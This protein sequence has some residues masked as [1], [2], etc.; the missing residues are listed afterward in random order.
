LL[1]DSTKEY[2]FKFPSNGLANMRFG[3]SRLWRS[4][5][6]INSFVNA[7]PKSQPFYL[8]S[9]KLKTIVVITLNTNTTIIKIII[10]NKKFVCFVSS[11]NIS[12]LLYFFRIW[13]RPYY[14]NII[15]Y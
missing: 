11:S 10:G 3:G 4:V 2:T 5:N 9:N 8:N 15:T 1:E 13:T 12:L 6:S 7:W 14:K